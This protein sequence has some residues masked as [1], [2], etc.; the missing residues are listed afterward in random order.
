MM[1]GGGVGK[2]SRTHKFN[3]RGSKRKQKWM[4]NIQ[5]S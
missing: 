3:K 5:I 1:V 4:T 2:F